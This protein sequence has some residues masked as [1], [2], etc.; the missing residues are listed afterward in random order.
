RAVPRSQRRVGRGAQALWPVFAY[1]GRTPMWLVLEVAVR[2]P[3][4]LLE[5]GERE[6]LRPRRGRMLA[7]AALPGGGRRSA[8]GSGPH[9][10]G[11]AQ[12]DC[13]D[14]PTPG[15]PVRTPEHAASGARE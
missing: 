8:R 13:R 7:G 12:Q 9:E 1:F 11:D 5:L 3:S 15:V 6:R 4:A 2:L 10:S 14:T